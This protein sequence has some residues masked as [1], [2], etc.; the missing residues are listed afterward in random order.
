M[1]P[2]R[3]SALHGAAAAYAV[4][5]RV[6]GGCTAEAAVSE[7]SGPRVGGCIRA[8]KNFRPHPVRREAGWFGIWYSA[9]GHAY[10]GLSK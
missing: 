2:H 6:C 3:S 5:S 9:C 1:H 8:C 10:W 4:H 7:A